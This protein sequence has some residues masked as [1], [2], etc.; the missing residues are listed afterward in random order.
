MK[1]KVEPKTDVVKKV[2]KRQAQKRPKKFRT[3]DRILEIWHQESEFIDN[4]LALLPVNAS[5]TDEHL[6]DYLLDL[7]D[8]EESKK[9]TKFLAKTQTMLEAKVKVKDEEG[10]PQSGE[11]DSRTNGHAE[12]PPMSTSTS[13][14]KD[15]KGVKPSREEL[16]ERLHAK[17]ALVGQSH[18]PR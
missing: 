2:P 11:V 15:S 7:S 14:K 13:N 18:F 10:E 6:E 5:E 8:S 4:L 9:R 16:L 3:S 17:I 1:N 12:V